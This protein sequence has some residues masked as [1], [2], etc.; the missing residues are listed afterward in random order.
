M[1]Y[2]SYFYV[3]MMLATHEEQELRQPK[4]AHIYSLIK[5]NDKKS[6]YLAFSKDI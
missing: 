2:S 3:T 4:M 5:P 1:I 6:F